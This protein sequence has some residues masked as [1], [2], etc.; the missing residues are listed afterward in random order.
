MKPPRAWRL[1]VAAGLLL[2]AG[3]LVAVAVAGRDPMDDAG[4]AYP[5]PEGVRNPLGPMGAW[6]GAE[7]GSGRYTGR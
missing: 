3:V 2:A 6:L 1:D 4:R 5:A 7:P